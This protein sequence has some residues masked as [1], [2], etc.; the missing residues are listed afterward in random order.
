MLG[1][2]AQKPVPTMAFAMDCKPKTVYAL[3]QMRKGMCF[4][5]AICEGLHFVLMQVNVHCWKS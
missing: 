5:P 4:P 3:M 2:R 1:G